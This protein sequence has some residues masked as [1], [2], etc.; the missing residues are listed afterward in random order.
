[1][2]AKVGKK[3]YQIELIS[4]YQK[5][6]FLLQNYVFLNTTNNKNKYKI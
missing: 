2:C 1:M 4:K 3:E 6:I 5:R